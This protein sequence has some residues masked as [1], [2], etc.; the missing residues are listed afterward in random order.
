MHGFVHKLKYI[1]Y[2][3]IRK[4]EKRSLKIKNIKH[5]IVILTGSLTTSP[6]L[7]SPASSISV[8]GSLFRIPPP[9][10]HLHL[11]PYF[12]FLPIPMI[13][14]FLWS[15]RPYSLSIPILSPSLFSPNPNSLPIPILSSSLLSL[16]PYSLPIPILSSSLLSL[17]P[18]SLPIPVLS[19]SLFSLHPYSLPI[20]ILSPSLYSPHPYHLFILIHSPSLFSPHPYSFSIPILFPSL[21]SDHP[22]SLPIPILSPS[23]FSAHP[24][25]LPIPILCPSL[26]NLPA[27]INSTRLN[28]NLFATNSQLP[29]SVLPIR[30]RIGSAPM[31]SRYLTLPSLSPSLFHSPIS[32]SL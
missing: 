3:S 11:F 24:Y 20:P 23:L 28:Q 10:N 31:Q 32:F 27:S 29:G 12:H 30:I 13:S 14:P 17:Y 26:G 18:Y 1:W 21:F 25:F 6:I 9:H 19:P 16:Y 5:A 15:P 2:C 22:Y 7:P 8:P 4:T